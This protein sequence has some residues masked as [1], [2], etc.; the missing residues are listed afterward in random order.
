MGF[1]IFFVYKFKVEHARSKLIKNSRLMHKISQDGNI[2]KSDRK[3]IGDLLCALSSNKDKI[4]YAVI[5]AS[6]AVAI[7]VAIYLDFLK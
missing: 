7:A 3:L 5:F 1:F 2:E 4:N 6:S